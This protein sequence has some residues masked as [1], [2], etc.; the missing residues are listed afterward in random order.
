M[1]TYKGTGVAII[2]I[3]FILLVI[4]LFSYGFDQ[5]VRRGE[6]AVAALQFL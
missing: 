2:L 3:L 1:S 6:C 4:I 5:I